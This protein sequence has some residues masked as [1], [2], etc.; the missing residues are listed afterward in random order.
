M[1][2]IIVIVITLL[3]LLSCKERIYEG[4]S[5]FDVYKAIYSDVFQL[6]MNYYDIVSEDIAD[7]SDAGYDTVNDIIEDYTGDY[8]D[9][10]IDSEDVSEIQEIRCD[11][12]IYDDISN[13][14]S[15]DGGGEDVENNVT[16]F[17]ESNNLIRDYAISKDNRVI[18]LV[19]W[20][21]NILMPVHK[22]H[23]DLPNW[24]VFRLVWITTDG[25][26]LNEHYFEGISTS[27]PVISDDNYVYFMKSNG[28]LSKYDIYGNPV[29]SIE[30]YDMMIGTPETIDIYF[31]LIVDKDEVYTIISEIGKD[32]NILTKVKNDKIEW[33]KRLPLEDYTTCEWSLLMGSDRNLYCC[34]LLKGEVISIS[35]E[36]GEER[37]RVSIDK[38]YLVRELVPDWDNNIYVAGYKRT[39]SGNKLGVIAKIRDGK[40]EWRNYTN[41]EFRTF[42]KVL[43]ILPDNR[44][45]VISDIVSGYSTDA[46]AYIVSNCGEKLREKWLHR[47]MTSYYYVVL[48]DGGILLKDYY[49]GKDRVI[50]FDSDLN[51]E[52]IA[53]DTVGIMANGCESVFFESREG[54]F[55]YK[56]RELGV[57][58]VPWPMPRGDAQNTGRVQKW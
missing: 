53:D 19:E 21:K 43:T 28:Y 25:V 37:W 41:R 14:C 24:N 12:V 35:S 9:Y 45:I 16:R 30:L 50:R 1:K 3:L 48:S 15:Y 46:H 18:V 8:T 20:V 38:D 23:L 7:L 39:E 10:S 26:I 51:F 56:L 42:G 44:I 6:D 58:K 29:E 49:D 5:D 11:S 33:Q 31:P 36:D 54:L 52:V 27:Y 4:E 13:Y 22:N 2:K 34:N 17:Y 40:V 47:G 57:A 32:Y 55:T